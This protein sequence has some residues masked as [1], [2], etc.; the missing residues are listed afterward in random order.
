MES[1][2]NSAE[3]QRA[4]SVTSVVTLGVVAAFVVLVT[5]VGIVGL[6]AF[7][8][9]TRTKQLGTRRA[10]GATKFHILRYF[11]VE[12][13]LIT[14]VGALIGCALALGSGDQAQHDVPDAAV[15]VVLSGGWRGGAMVAGAAGSVAA[16]AACG[17]DFAGDGDADGL[18]GE[19]PS[20]AGRLERS[21]GR[22]LSRAATERSFFPLSRPAIEGF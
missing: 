18:R 10:I 20:I 21:S 22:S 6:A 16:G 7:T 9:A 15:A 3:R 13:W 12:N 17:G 14:S 19:E 2:T 8:V 11:L 5:V 4:G 1:L